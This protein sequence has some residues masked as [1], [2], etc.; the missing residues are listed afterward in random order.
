TI[1][2]SAAERSPALARTAAANRRADPFLLRR[3]SDAAQSELLVDLRRHSCIHAGGAV[4]HRHRARHAL[5]AAHRPRLQ[6]R[7]A[8]HARRELWLAAAL[9]PFER[10]LDVLPRRL[11]P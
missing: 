3:L 8:D 11:H 4:R 10:R 5:Y 7:R 6:L 9:P 2:L 1:D